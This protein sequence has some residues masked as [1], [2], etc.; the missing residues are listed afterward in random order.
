MPGNAAGSPLLICFFVEFFCFED[1]K[2]II[3]QPIEIDSYSPKS[4]YHFQRK[5]EKYLKTL[6]YLFMILHKR[7]KPNITILKFKSIQLAFNLFLMNAG[8]VCQ[9]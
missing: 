9:R 3:I 2:T 4:N 8:S 5:E 6:F 1:F 7:L